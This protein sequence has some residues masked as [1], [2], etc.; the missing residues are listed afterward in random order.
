MSQKGRKPKSSPLKI[1]RGSR[2]D[3]VAQPAKSTPAAI[4]RPDQLD[5]FGRQAWDRVTRELQTAGRLASADRE[6]I[7]L[8]CAAYSRWRRADQELAALG[9]TIN[10]DLGGVKANPA[11]QVV[12]QAE[13]TMAAMLNELGLTPS[14][15][16]RF[17]NPA[18]KPVDAL[19]EFLAR[20]K[21]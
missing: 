16:C 4:A 11:A 5:E 3:R 1:L 10:T 12:A 8:Y 7:E 20:R 21:A 15:R 18:E 14:S 19:A 9:V 2:A 17:G 13:R 6:A